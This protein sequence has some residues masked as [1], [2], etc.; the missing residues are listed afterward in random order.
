MPPFQDGSRPQADRFLLRLAF[1]QPAIGDFQRQVLFGRRESG[2]GF[3]QRLD[4][5]LGILLF[6]GHHN[7]P[8]PSHYID[9]NTGMGGWQMILSEV[10]QIRGGVQLNAPSPR[11]SFGRRL[12]RT[13]AIPEGESSLRLSTPLWAT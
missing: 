8:I 1:G 9:P 13:A 12:P 5:Q 10:S 7:P 11:T 2:I 4:G 6:I 3:R